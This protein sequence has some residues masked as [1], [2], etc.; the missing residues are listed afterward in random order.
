MLSG[1]QSRHRDLL[2]VVVPGGRL[3]DGADA[4]QRRERAH[5][6]DR[7]LDVARQ[8]DERASRSPDDGCVDGQPRDLHAAVAR[9]A[10]RGRGVR[11]PIDRRLGD[12]LE[13]RR[14]EPRATRS[15]RLAVNPPASS[16]RSA[17]E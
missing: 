4:R 13:A 1:E 6:A 12:D 17:S 9:G 10:N 14:G 5:A 2:H 11:Q 16:S 3:G 15:V 7:R 8:R